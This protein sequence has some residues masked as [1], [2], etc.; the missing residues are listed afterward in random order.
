MTRLSLDFVE[1]FPP[2]VAYRTKFL[3]FGGCEKVAFGG[4]ARGCNENASYNDGTLH[5]R[6]RTI[7]D[8]KLTIF[9][10]SMIPEAF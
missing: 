4:C 9:L 7:I 5:P 2:F 3:A 6:T 8:E 1:T 10:S